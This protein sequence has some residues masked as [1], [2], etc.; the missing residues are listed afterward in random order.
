MISWF[1]VR[2]SAVDIAICVKMHM[3]VF[4]EESRYMK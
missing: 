4:V 2:C 1:F 3:V